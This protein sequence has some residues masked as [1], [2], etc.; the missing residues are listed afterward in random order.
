MVQFNEESEQKDSA[1]LRIREQEDLTRLLSEKYGLPY[2]DLSLVPVNIDALREV[3]EA[4][5]RKGRLAP[6]RITGKILHVATITPEDEET[7]RVLAV[8]EGRRF[9]VT[10]YVT[11]KRSLEKAWEYY[12]DVALSIETTGGILDIS[13]EKIKGYL[14]N[15][16][17]T[18]DVASAIQEALQGKKR[19]QTTA[20]LELLIASAIATNASD[21]HIE[22]KEGEVE[23]RFRLDGVLH[24]LSAVETNVSALLVSRIKLLSGMKLNVKDAAQD[25]RFSVNLDEDMEIRS[26]AIPGAYGESVVLRIL[27]PKTI[28][29]GFLDLGIEPYLLGLIEKEIAKPNG[30]IITTGPTGSGK[31]TTLYAFLKKLHTPEVK[32]V[33][34]EDPIEYHLPGVTQTQVDQE[35][36]Y[37]FSEGLRSALRQDPDIIMVGEIRDNDT[38][39][40]AIHA[41]L[42][43]HMVLSTL[44]T[45]DAAGAIPRLTDMGINPKVLGSALNAVL[46][47]RLIRRLCDACKKQ[48]PATDEERRY[49]ETVVATLPERYKKEAAGVDFTSLFHVVGCDVCSSIGYKGRIGVYEAIIMDATIEN[50]VKGGPSARELREVANAQGLLTLVQDGILK[51][52]KGVT[53]LSELKRV[54]GE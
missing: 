31:T 44:H 54:V 10:L 23:I 40:T 47:Q 3:P 1:E 17:T 26:S 32:I 25:G 39:S 28:R 30:T 12:K 52:I 48:E 20:L 4:D 43:G 15:I 16:K 37:T 24:E 2:T 19:Y 51:V 8:L 18:A 7:R 38:A 34:I 21:I 22:P 14:G 35:G 49:I 5:A 11:S 41:A 42:T 9:K 45:N 13:Q 27:N 53:T 29:V 36:G 6:F 33:T 50:S 46:A